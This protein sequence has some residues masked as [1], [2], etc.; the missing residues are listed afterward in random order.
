MLLIVVFIGVLLYVFKDICVL[1]CIVDM[2]FE[3][4]KDYDKIVVNIYFVVYFVLD[5]FSYIIEYGVV[6]YNN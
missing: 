4:G 5:E 1:D 6:I 2:N 3:L